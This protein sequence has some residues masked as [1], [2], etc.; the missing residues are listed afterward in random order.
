MRFNTHS[1]IIRTFLILFL[2]GTVNLSFGQT[3]KQ[4]INFADKNYAVGDYYGASIYYRKAMDIDSIDVHLL[5]KYAESCRQYNEYV[6]AER[7]YRKVYEKE[8]GKLYPNSLFMAATMQK[9]N[10]EYKLAKDNYKKVLKQYSRNKKS[11]EYLKAKQEQRSCSF[12][13][14]MSKDTV[15][16]TIK[17]LGNDVNTFDSEFAPLLYDGLLYFCSLR[18]EKMNENFEVN[19]PYYKIK[20]YKA[21]RN[22]AGNSDKSWETEGE[23]DTT[24]NSVVS[25]NANSTFSADGKRFYFTR[26][27]ASGCKIMVSK[28]ENDHWAVPTEVKEANSDASNST[29]PMVAQIDGKEFLFFSSNKKGGQGKMDIWSIEMGEGGS[30]YGKAKNAGKS[31]NSIDDEITPFYDINQNVLYFSSNWHDGLGGFDVF[32]AT[33]EPG[34]YGV[35]ENMGY[36]INTSWNDIYFGVEPKGRFGYMA[37]NRIGSLYKKGPTCCNDIWEIEWPVNEEPLDTIPYASLEDLNKY[38]PVT[39]YFHNDEPNPRSN[40]TVTKLTYMQTY[41]SYNALHD[42]YVEE[43]RKG[44]DAGS[45]QKAED[46]IVDFFNDYVDKGVS[47]LEIFLPLLLKELEKGQKVELTI[48]GFASPLAKTD[49]NVRLTGRRITSLMNYMRV[50]N[51]GVFIPYLEGTAPNGGF[52]QYTKIPFGEYTADKTISDDVK[53]TKISIYS[54]EASLER[55]IEIQTV[56]RLNKDTLIS[57]LRMVKDSYDFGDVTKGDILKHTFTFTNTG[58]MDLMIDTV[59][60]MCGCNTVDYP[61][62]AIKP[63]EKGQVTVTFDT[64]KYDGMQVRSVTLVTNGFPANKRLVVTAEIFEK[65]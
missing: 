39:L 44:L 48:K 45:A 18:S 21:H 35:P 33:G 15:G 37:S 38:L 65:K 17:N 54:K 3:Y 51:N 31:I 64:G 8:G 22:G 42:K 36:P 5:W 9:Y 14:K 46:K 57:E 52:L 40:D 29:Q 1:N 58:D 43:N 6:I 16:Y 30:S 27:D 60:V 10:G 56:Q 13:M 61:K 50:Y 2:I 26:C 63:G 53:N 55:K 62:E 24:I 20:I 25:N 59:L 49:Y 34:K 41:E 32:K 4:L 23:I 47:D 28:F 7:Y 11:Y 19:D 12:A